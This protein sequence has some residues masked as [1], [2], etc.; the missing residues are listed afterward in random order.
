MAARYTVE[1]LQQGQQRPYGDSIYV[2]RFSIEH[3]HAEGGE[4]VP[5]DIIEDRVRE[6]LKG[7]PST[8]FTDYVRPTG[9]QLTEGEH[10]TKY[11]VYLKKVEP[12]VWEF[13]CVSAF[14]D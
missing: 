3:N 4:W 11:L 7:I 1:H 5:F 6:L 8:G 13:K 12:G 10:F 2:T 9:R 14:C